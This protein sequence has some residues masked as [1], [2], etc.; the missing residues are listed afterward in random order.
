MK[1]RICGKVAQLD[2]KPF[3][4]RTCADIDLAHWLRGTYV[5]SRPLDESDLSDIEDK[6]ADPDGTPRKH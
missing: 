2:Y 6:G 5:T 4:S 3:C 1:C